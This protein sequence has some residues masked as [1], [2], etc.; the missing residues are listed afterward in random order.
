MDRLPDD[1]ILEDRLCLALYRASHAMTAAYRAILEPL[2][3][4]YPQYTVMSALW[5]SDPRTVK[6]LSQVLGSDYN[7]VS[8]LIKRL[9][10]RD[11]LRRRRSDADEREVLVQLTDRGRALQEGAR[12]VQ[13]DVRRAVGLSETRHNR[14]LAD[15]QQLTRQ[16][17]NFT[18]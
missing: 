15:L 18:R 9:E 8:P 1:D 12:S 13:P 10:Q 14:L 4:T 17:H 3:L 2:D 6:D 7:T 16:L 5:Q 11:L